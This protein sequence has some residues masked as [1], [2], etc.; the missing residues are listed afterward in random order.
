[1]HEQI[2]ATQ[3]ARNLSSL[4]DEVRL[5]GKPLSITRGKREVAQLIPPRASG[6]SSSLLL[7][8]LQQSPLTRS[9]CEDFSKDID[10][11]R[12]NADLPPS[13]WE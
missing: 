11:I 4:I 12:Q 1:M 7:N 2:S 5:G 3:L 10:T 6:A 9:E 13:S 8:L